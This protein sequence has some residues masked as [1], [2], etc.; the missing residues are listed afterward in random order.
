M[1]EVDYFMTGECGTDFKQIGYVNMWELA[2]SG[3]VRYAD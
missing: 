3:Y 1:Q 2:L